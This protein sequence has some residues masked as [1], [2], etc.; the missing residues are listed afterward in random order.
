MRK[1]WKAISFEASKHKKI[2][3]I[4]VTYELLCGWLQLRW[5]WAFKDK[6]RHNTD[7]S[8]LAGMIEKGEIVEQSNQYRYF[9]CKFQRQ[10]RRSN[11]A[12]GER[13]ML[14]MRQKLS[15][16]FLVFLV[17]V[18]TGCV[19]TGGKNLDTAAIKKGVSTKADVVNL[20]GPPD[21]E[22]T[23]G[24]GSMLCSWVSVREKHN[25][26][27]GA[28]ITKGIDSTDQENRNSLAGREVRQVNVTFSSEGVVSSVTTS[29]QGS[30]E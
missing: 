18:F 5:Y 19:T 4:P 17:F 8:T 9:A 16:V 30:V 6:F 20:L 15:M 14:E 10:L 24:D 7:M 3:V 23:L 25:L 13:F 28:L 12:K 27:W 1:K 22:M 11:M 21:Q 26:I 2:S 29:K